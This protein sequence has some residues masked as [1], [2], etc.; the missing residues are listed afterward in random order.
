MEI[1]GDEADEAAARAGVFDVGDSFK[2]L[3]TPEVTDGIDE[4]LSG[5]VD[6][7]E[8]WDADHGVIHPADDS[9]PRLLGDGEAYEKEECEWDEKPEKVISRKV[10][11]GPSGLGIILSASEGI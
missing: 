7:A 8:K 2:F 5:G 1:T 3:R 10:I 4:L 11:K 6:E 9:F